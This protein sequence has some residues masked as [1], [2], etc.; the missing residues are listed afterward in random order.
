MCSNRM[1]S[2]VSQNESID[3][4]LGYN[5]SNFEGSASLLPNTTIPDNGCQCGSSCNCVYCTKHPTNAAT[6][7]RID[8]LYNLMDD[9]SPEEFNQEGQPSSSYDNMIPTPHPF[10]LTSDFSNQPYIQGYQH[11]D[12]QQSGMGQPSFY[13]MA[14]PVAGCAN[15]RCRC[16]DNCACDGCL[17]H[18]GHLHPSLPI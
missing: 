13:E 15:G 4:R 7:D 2:Q 11:P 18:T 5:P 16:G 17:T 9:E 6:R 12:S 10:E 3:S 8:E 14:F 1:T